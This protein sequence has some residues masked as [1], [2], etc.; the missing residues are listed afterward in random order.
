MITDQLKDYARDTRLN[1]EALTV[2]EG[3]PGLK[4]EQLAGAALACAYAL[5]STE[6]A[7]E[8][9][10]RYQIGEATQEAAKGAAVIMAMNNV[11]YRSLHLMEDAEV[12]RLPARLRMN[13]IGKPG[14]ERLDFE[15]MCLAVSALAGCGMCLK[16]HAAELR[17][18]GI[19]PVGVQSAIRI[20]SVIQSAAAA[21]RIA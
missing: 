7:T 11:Y 15:V 10:Q 21:L 14:I 17:K 16:S 4:P 6:L 12:S 20:A 2:P 9:A 5:G 18:G 3:A 8:L 19:E 1:L 13:I